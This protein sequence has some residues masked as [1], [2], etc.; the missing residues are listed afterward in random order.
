MLCEPATAGLRS[1][2]TKCDD[3]TVATGVEACE[4]SVVD[5]LMLQF[6]LDYM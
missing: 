6:R 5:R 3:Q 2:M 4:A 1:E